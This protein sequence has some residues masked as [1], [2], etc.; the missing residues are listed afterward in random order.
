MLSFEWGNE[1]MGK[2]WNENNILYHLN[3]YAHSNVMQNHK[4]NMNYRMNSGHIFEQR[5]TP[6]LYP[7]FDKIST[8]A[9]QF[10]TL[11]SFNEHE[12]IIIS[13]FKFVFH[14]YVCA[15]SFLIIELPS[16]YLSKGKDN[17]MWKCSRSSHK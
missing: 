13:F 2:C 4:V 1:K 15:Q 9:L 16:F 17:R 12:M 14:N 8:Q 3:K 7:N 5:W 6:G 11:N 10:R